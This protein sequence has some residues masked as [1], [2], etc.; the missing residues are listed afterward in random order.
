M[1]NKILNIINNFLNENN[2]MSDITDYRVLHVKKTILD[3]EITPSSGV[4]LMEELVKI[5]KNNNNILEIL[6][7][8]KNDKTIIRIIII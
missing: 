8:N 1:S 5:S 6:S 7:T 3:L 2:M 4:I